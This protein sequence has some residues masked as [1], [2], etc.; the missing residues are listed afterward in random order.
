MRNLILILVLMPF[1]AFSQMFLPEVTEVCFFHSGSD[2]R[3]CFAADQTFSIELVDNKYFLISSNGEIKKYFIT[4]YFAN[5]KGEISDDYFEIDFEGEI[6][7]ISKLYFDTYIE[8]VIYNGKENI[9]YSY[10]KREQ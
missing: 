10:E 1:M 9:V 2:E 5:D 4:S 6:N 3:E 8:V 7:K